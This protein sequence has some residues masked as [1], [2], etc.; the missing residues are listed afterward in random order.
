MSEPLS[1]TFIA[2]QIIST[3]ALILVFISFQQ[4]SRQKLLR[5]QITTSLLSAI[6]FALLS[7]YPGSVACLTSAGRNYIFSKH[8][9]GKAPAYWYAIYLMVLIGLSLYTYQ[10]PI[11]LLPML[12]YGLYGTAVWRG[13]AQQIRK[14]DVIACLIMYAYILHTLAYVSLI[15]N[16]VEMAASIVGIYRH[17]TSKEQAKHLRQ[18]EIARNR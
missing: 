13:S 5:Y 15:S 12:A 1:A 14:A 8:P 18:R 7:G 2:A 9:T 3:I 17:R 4:K 6:Q 16:S 10:T 11:D